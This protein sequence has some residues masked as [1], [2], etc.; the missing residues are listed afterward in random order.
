[1]RS[2]EILSPAVPL[3][4][5][6]VSLRS[7]RAS[8]LDAISDAS[9][10]PETRQWL[11]DPPMDAE[12]RVAS[13][14][15]VAE[16][17][18]TGRSAPLVIADHES[19]E[20]IGLINLQFRDDHLATIAYSVFPAHRGKSVAPRAVRLMAEWAFGDLRLTELWLEIDPRNVA[21]IRVAEKCGFEPAEANA[22][23]TGKLVFVARKPGE[24][25]RLSNDSVS[26]V[27][28]P[29]R[30]LPGTTCNSAHG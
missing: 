16:A 20:P 9:F 2:T 22:D 18:R 27:V 24:P 28:K 13:M 5:G 14:E 1:M 19:D 8:D 25:E 21:S 4:D 12:A 23:G 15:R 10:D 11:T 30:F 26:G 3:S 29:G 6:I 17:F 7:R